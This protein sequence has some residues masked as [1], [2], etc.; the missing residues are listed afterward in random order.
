[1]L[2]F[3]WS[4]TTEPSNSCPTKDDG[5]CDELQTCSLGTDSIDC[6]KMCNQFTRETSLPTDDEDYWKDVAICAFDNSGKEPNQHRTFGIP[7]EGS[8]GKVG[9]YDDMVTVRS[10]YESSEV[11][12][13]YRVYVPRR[14]DPSV[15]TPVMVALGGFSVDMYWLAEFT[16]LNRMADRENFIVIYGHPEWRD[17]G[18][19]D[20]FSWYVYL[21]A[22]QGDWIDNPDIVYMEAVIEEVKELYNIDLSRIYVSGH[23]RGGALSIIAA[24]ERPDLFAGYC[25][26]AGFASSNEYDIRLQELVQTVKVPGILVHGEKDP[27]VGVRESDRISTIFSDANWQYTEDWLYFK[28]PNATHEWQSQYNQEMWDWLADRPNINHLP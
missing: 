17:F 23:S 22:Y 27:D 7:S 6:N 26:Q 3:L 2:L 20:V 28:I 5:V 25:A 13:Y 14:Y 16:E 24:F 12:R 19:F 9:T 11:E 21:Q 8:G 4:C 10:D 15:P 18:N 1:M